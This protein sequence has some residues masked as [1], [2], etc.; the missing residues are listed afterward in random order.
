MY[1]NV[2]LQKNCILYKNMLILYSTVFLTS[3]CFVKEQYSNKYF[4]ILTN[5]YYVSGAII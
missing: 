5:I 4:I 2:G 3:W 1:M